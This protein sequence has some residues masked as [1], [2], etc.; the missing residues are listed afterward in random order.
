MENRNSEASCLQCMFEE[1]GEPIVLTAKM[2]ESPSNQQRFY[3]G[4]GLSK[5]PVTW[6][7][8]QSSECV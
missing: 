1:F 2:A 5:M 3:K 8:R 7:D 4:I 6:A